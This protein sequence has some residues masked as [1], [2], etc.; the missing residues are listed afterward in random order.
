MRILHCSDLHGNKRWFDWLVDGAANFDL[1]CVTGDFLDLLDLKRIDAQL[2]MVAF[3]LDRITVPVAL[4]SGNNDSFNGPPTPPSLLHATWLR[5]LRGPGRWIDGDR[6]E[7]SGKRFRCVGWNAPLPSAELDEV[8]LYHAP[9]ARSI[10]AIDQLGNDSGDEMLREMC[11]ANKGPALVLSG[12]QHEPREWSCRVGRS[13]CLNPGYNAGAVI[14][15]HIILDLESRHAE[16][17]V[18]GRPAGVAH[19]GV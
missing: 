7:L 1:V 16:L 12:H 13:W 10:T 15:N 4:C 5:D 2:N 9:P 18:G 8:W 3:A 17:R 14:P 11:Q 19:L 6:F